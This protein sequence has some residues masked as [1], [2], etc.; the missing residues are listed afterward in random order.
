MIRAPG[1]CDD[2]RG[3]TALLAIART[4]EEVGITTDR[5][6]LFVATVGEEGLG[7]LRGVRHLFGADGAAAEA[8][9]FISLDGAGDSR[10]VSHGLG[11]GPGCG[12]GSRGREAIPGWTGGWAT[13]ST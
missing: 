11:G 12:S 6:L 4:M 7:D 1:I 10:V 3:L 2:G 8:C 5:P 9:G 13:R